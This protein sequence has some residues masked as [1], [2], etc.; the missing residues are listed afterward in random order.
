MGEH[1]AVSSTM[2]FCKGGAQMY[3]FA[4]N[5]NLF[6]SKETDANASDGT[7]PQELRTA[8]EKLFSEFKTTLV[9]ATNMESAKL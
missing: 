7:P 1:P 5:V 9:G 4:I 2:G 8:A 3:V 6:P